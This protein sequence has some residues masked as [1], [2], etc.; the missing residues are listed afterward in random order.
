MKSIGM[1]LLKHRL[2]FWAGDR[3]VVKLDSPSLAARLP[4]VVSQAPLPELTT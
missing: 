4:L 2:S 1:W 3:E